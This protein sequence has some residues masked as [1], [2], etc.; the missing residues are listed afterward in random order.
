MPNTPSKANFFSNVNSACRNAQDGIEAPITF[1][2]IARY[3][4]VATKKR[5]PVNRAV[6]MPAIMPAT[7][8][9]AFKNSS[10]FCS[11][12]VCENRI[13]RNSLNVQGD[14]DVAG[15]RDGQPQYL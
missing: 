13:L 10:I 4:M 9:K 5:S 1:G 15:R 2:V 11:E 6:S 3:D 7:N 8:I 12:N 14:R